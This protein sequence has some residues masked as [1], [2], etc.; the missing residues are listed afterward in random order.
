MNKIQQLNEL[1]K[2]RSDA[3]KMKKELEKEELTVEEGS[4][5]FKVNGAQEVLYSEK[6]GIEQPE[7]TKGINKAMKEAQKTAAQKMMQSGGGLSGLL[8]GK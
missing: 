7:V 3:M 2:M 5:R 6:D 1:R 8:G 4:W